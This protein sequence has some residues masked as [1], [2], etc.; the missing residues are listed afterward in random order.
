MIKQST[1][2]TCKIVTGTR[3]PWLFQIAVIPRLRAITPILIEFGLHFVDSEESVEDVLAAFAL[4]VT[5]VRK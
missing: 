5:L 3:T 2:L 1:S 4:A